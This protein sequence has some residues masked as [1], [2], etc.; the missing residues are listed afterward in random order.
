MYDGDVAV[1]EKNAVPLMKM[2]NFMQMRPLKKL[3]GEFLARY[4]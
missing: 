4:V 3:A 2:A 1:T